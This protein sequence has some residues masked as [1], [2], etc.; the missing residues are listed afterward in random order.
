MKAFCEDMEREIKD[1]WGYVSAWEKIQ[2]H[3]LRHLM[4]TKHSKWLTKDEH[5]AVMH[6]LASFAAEELE[7]LEKAWCIK[8]QDRLEIRIRGLVEEIL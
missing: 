3:F 7:F 1:D 8:N 5:D 4:L 2:E 6:A